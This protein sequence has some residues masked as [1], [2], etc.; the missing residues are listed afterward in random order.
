MQPVEPKSVEIEWYKFCKELNIVNKF[1]DTK[2]HKA[3][4]KK[5]NDRQR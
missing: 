5:L 3:I 2:F 4:L 1:T